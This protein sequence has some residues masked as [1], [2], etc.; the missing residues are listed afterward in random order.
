MAEGMT[1]YIQMKNI[2]DEYTKE[3]AEVLEDALQ[4]TAKEARQKLKDSSPRRHGDYAEGWTTKR[5]S[6]TA[7]VVYNKKAPSLTHLLEYSHLIVNSKGVQKRRNGG[8]SE[9]DAHPHIKPVEE[10]ANAELVR[11]VERG[12]K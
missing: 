2:L 10:W 3:V 9:T 12:L 5:S 11:K 4:T 1:V 6:E 7:I 8:G